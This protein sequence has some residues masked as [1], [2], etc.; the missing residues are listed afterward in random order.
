MVDLKTIIAEGEDVPLLMRILLS[1]SRVKTLI[2]HLAFAMTYAE[3]EQQAESICSNLYLLDVLVNHP[4]IREVKLLWPFGWNTV[5]DDDIE[6]EVDPKVKLQLET[7]ARAWKQCQD[8]TITLLGLCRQKEVIQSHSL[9]RDVIG[10]VAR[11]VWRTRGTE[12]W[13]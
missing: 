6:F 10:I 3:A 11:M 7:N 8:V 1:H 2:W 4:T 13:V 9:S 12:V 5:G